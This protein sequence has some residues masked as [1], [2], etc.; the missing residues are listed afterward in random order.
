MEEIELTK[1][2]PRGRGGI[3]VLLAL[4]WCAVQGPLR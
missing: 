2:V 3:E 4:W 1:S